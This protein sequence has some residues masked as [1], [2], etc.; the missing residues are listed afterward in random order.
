MS[1]DTVKN[2]FEKNVCK[3]VEKARFM[4]QS[5]SP[6]RLVTK[7]SLITCYEN[8]KYLDDDGEKKPF[9]KAW[10]VDPDMRTYKTTSDMESGLSWD[11][12]SGRSTNPTARCGAMGD[13]IRM[14]D[15]V[16]NNDNDISECEFCNDYGQL[17]VSEDIYT[18]CHFCT[19]DEESTE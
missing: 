9:L 15:N 18:S 8:M 3:I 5:P 17:Y 11:F 13:S 6:P 7:S 12:W 1:Y 10:F 4:R 16:C 2:E 14:N 19:D